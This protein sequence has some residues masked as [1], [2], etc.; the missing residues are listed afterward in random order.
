MVIEKADQYLAACVRAV[1]ADQ[2]APPWPAGFAT[3]EQGE[4]VSL[5]ASFHGIAVLLGQKPATLE[6]WPAPVAEDVRSEMRLTGL[7]EELHRIQVANVINKLAQSG[8]ASMLLKGTALAYLFYADPA[9]RRRGDSDMLNRP[10][11][12]ARTRTILEKAGY[13]RREDPH[14]LFFQETWLIDCG[15]QMEHSIDLHWEPNDRPVLQKTL[16]AGHFWQKPVPVPRLSPH[17]AAP[18]PVMMM[19]HGAFNQAWHLARGYNVDSERVTGGRRLIWAVDYLNLTQRF[20]DSQWEELAAF[21]EKHDAAAIVYAAF[22]GARQDVGLVVPAA[23][24]DRLSRASVG[25]VTHAYITKPG[26]VRDFMRDFCA[27]ESS[28]MRMRLLHGFVFAPRS[29]LIEKYPRMSHW[30]T[31]LL[32]LRRYSS[33]F[34]RWRKP[35]ETGE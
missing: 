30:P 7:W 18:D 25:S 15:A 24:M 22:E 27:A 1:L 35:P 3:A 26:V 33:V 10:D 6:S 2:E 17:A 21:C 16:R 9:A 8:I 4:T 29:H 5:R 14:G 31:A 11:D 34:G 19:V 12:L 23:I 13:Q 20:S 28:A 32:Q